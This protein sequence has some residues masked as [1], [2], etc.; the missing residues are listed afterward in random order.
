MPKF[1]CGGPN[2]ISAKTL[3]CKQAV[4]LV[5]LR[6]HVRAASKKETPL[7]ACFACPNKRA[8]LQA[9]KIEKKKDFA[10]KHEVCHML[11]LMFDPVTSRINALKAQVAQAGNMTLTRLK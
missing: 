5:E 6:E 1:T 11:C 8:C 10:H 3:P 7:T 2:A 9:R 4:H